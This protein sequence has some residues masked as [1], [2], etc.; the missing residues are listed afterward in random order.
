MVPSRSLPTPT[1]GSR[2]GP[3][4]V[5]PTRQARP[6]HAPLDDRPSHARALEFPGG[7]ESLED[8]EELAR[9]AHVEARPVVAHEVDPATVL[10]ARTDLDPGDLPR[11]G[12][13]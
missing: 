12:E 1:P 3:A 7:V 9:V 2:P 8:A 11:G 13:L 6:P 10:L 4:G 5:R